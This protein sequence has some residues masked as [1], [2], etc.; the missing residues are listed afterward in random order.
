MVKRFGVQTK[1]T[2]CKSYP[3]FVKIAQFFRDL[4][5]DNLQTNFKFS[6]GNEIINDTLLKRKPFKKEKISKIG[7]FFKSYCEIKEQLEQK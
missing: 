6:H 7:A 4:Q 1:V 3:N 5:T 2:Y